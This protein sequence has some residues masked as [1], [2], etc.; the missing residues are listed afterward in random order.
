VATVDL[1]QEQFV[2]TLA[3]GCLQDVKS[4][5]F[6]PPEV[7]FWISEDG[8]DFHLAGR[9]SNTFPEDKEG[10]FTQDYSLVL[11]QNIRYL[12]VKAVNYGVCP[13]WHLGAGGTT[14]LFADEL[15]VE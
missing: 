14:W 13:E 2:K 12:K 15:V 1:G 8:L 5:I 11:N 3:L 9:V 4:W 10:S 7:A 6:Y